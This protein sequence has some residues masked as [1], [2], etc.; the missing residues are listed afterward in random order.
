MQINDLSALNAF[1]EKPKSKT[2]SNQTGI[3]FNENVINRNQINLPIIKDDM[4]D[5]LDKWLIRCKYLNNGVMILPKNCDSLV[6]NRED[7][8]LH[9]YDTRFNRFVKAFIAEF[10]ARNFTNLYYTVIAERGLI[11]ITNINY[12]KSK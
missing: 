5:E 6:L 10:K 1:F 11:A 2:T 8:F 12:Q 7:K 4:Y 9:K 3:K